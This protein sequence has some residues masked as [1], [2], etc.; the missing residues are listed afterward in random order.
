MALFLVVSGVQIA[1]AQTLDA[2]RAR[3]HLVCGASN[4]LTGF[5]Q[6]SEDGLWSGFDVDFCRAVAA[7]VLGDPDLV[8]FRPMAGRARVAPLETGAVDL[9]ARGAAWTM[10]RDTYFG[11][12]YV[13]T[14]FFDGLAVMVPELAGIVS[15]YELDDVTVCVLEEP[16]ER[17]AIRDF[18]AEAATTYTE[19]LYEEREDLG[20]AYSAGLCQAIAAPASW[21]HAFR[22]ALPDPASSRILPE[23]LTKEPFGPMV[24]SNDDQWFNIVRWV[25]NVLIDAEELGVTSLNLEP[26]QSVRNPAIRRLMGLEGDFGAGMGLDPTWM[27]TVIRAVGNYGEVYARNFGTQTGA[28]LPRGANA[29]WIKGG[30]MYAPPV[31]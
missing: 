19:R 13:G 8:E 27:R 16:G 29:L 11:A 2:V 28:G 21:L 3:G 31:R 18:F 24:R 22:R 17:R 30:L 9:F 6:R 26:M 20:V 7:A 15:A 10:H 14:S 5:A 1:G 23:R 12:R 4:T 25:L